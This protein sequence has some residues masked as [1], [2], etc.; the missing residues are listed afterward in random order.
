MSQWIN[1]NGAHHIH[2]H[3]KDQNETDVPSIS[4][5]VLQSQPN[6]TA[7]SVL[8]RSGSESHILVFSVYFPNKSQVPMQLNFD[9][10]SHSNKHSEATDMYLIL[11][12]FL[13]LYNMPKERCIL[14]FQDV[15][16]KCSLLNICS[17][18]IF[19]KEW[20]HSLKLFWFQHSL[21]KSTLTFSPMVFLCLSSSPLQFYIID[22]LGLPHFFSILFASSTA[23]IF[24]I[25]SYQLT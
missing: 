7:S 19:H 20:K 4:L 6:H 16:S 1:E 13:S 18:D 11:Q 21:Q 8:G 15:P 24:P 22:Q 17:F 2:L 14:N 5:S 10:V 23:K 12:F 25:E 9:I 3:S